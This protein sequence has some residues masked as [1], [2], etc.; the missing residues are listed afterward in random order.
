MEDN[1]KEYFIKDTELNSIDE[2]RLNSKDIADNIE[3]IINNTEPSFAIALT[4]KTGLGK[5]SIINFMIEKYGNNDNYN[6]KKLNLWKDELGLKETLDNE[7]N[8]YS[9]Y[10][11]NTFNDIDNNSPENIEE[12]KFIEQPA[13]EEQSATI[14]KKNNKKAKK[15]LLSILK[16][17]AISGICFLITTAIFLLME[18]FSNSSI[19]SKNDLFFVQNAYLNY[20]ENLSFVFI[21]TLGLTVI[22]Y[23]IETLLSV[24]KSI[25]KKYRIN[26]EQEINLEAEKLTSIADV[27]QKNN[28]NN[29]IDLTKTN[30]VIVEDIDKL[31]L[32][33]MLKTLEDIKYCNNYKNVVLIVPF[34]ENILKKAI[35]ARNELKV[36]KNYKPVKF[37]KIMDKIFQFKISV[38]RISNSNIKNYAIQLANEKVQDF[39]DDY[40]DESTFKNII[41]KI[42]IYKN[43]T[44]PRHVKKLINSFINNKLLIQTR[45]NNGNVDESI[46][47][48]NGFD[49]QLAK[50]SVLQADFED[51][52]DLLFV[53]TG[54]LEKLTDLYC[55]EPTD[56]LE[57]YDRIDDDLKPFFTV[58]YR[59]LKSFLKQTRNYK[60]DN[61]STLIYLT[62]TKPDAFFKDKSLYGYVSGE[63]DVLELRIQE[64]LELVKRLDN[65]ED[66]S[67]FVD[68]NFDKLLDKFE[69]KASNKIFLVNFKQI[70]DIL[71]NYIPEPE[72]IRY[73]KIVANNYNYY[74][75]EALE[76]FENSQI[77]LTVELMNTLLERMQQSISKENFDRTFCFIRNNNDIIFEEGGNVSLY[78]QFLVN[79]ISLSSN[80]DE[81]IIELDD[82]FNRIGKVYE[83]N[84]NIKNLDN[85][86]YESAYKFLAKCLDNG[87]LA[88]MVTVI[89]TILS[90]N[91]SVEDCIKIEEKMTNY[92]LIDV[93]EC[94]ADDIV[95]YEKDNSETSET[96]ENSENKESIENAKLIE[97]NYVLIKNII[98]ICSIKQEEIAPED[99]IKFIEKALLNKDDENYL[100][101]I[102][103]L[104]N[105]FDSAYFYITRRELNDIIYSNFH[106]TQFEEVKKKCVQCTRYF[107]NARIFRPKLNED[108]IKIYNEN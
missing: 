61:I 50:L 42:I 48:N 85:L 107:K 1:L 98:E 102:Y 64:V 95:N 10:D 49:Y 82:N 43:V 92:S 90:D 100:L 88:R 56:L 46:I 35:N 103:D 22:A 105:K 58:K 12:S 68:N 33:K 21:F 8:D 65:E 7:L 16:F 86:D 38:P 44:T 73:L 83:L 69:D 30:I 57:V 99:S 81:V 34:D 3:T 19:Y 104:L 23:I 27:N 25:N 93:I 89:N 80:P 79:N 62:Q 40:C 6:I 75:T 5:S 76:I 47:E 84:K 37:E 106:T 59:P 15:I 66:L 67:E 28:C 14:N 96:I 26:V 71:Y 97:N 72:Y 20:K 63:E 17:I 91:N 36:S 32:S 78:V 39:I 108:E 101:Q 51:F 4:G 52:Y 94:N 13:I 45:V 74:D 9:E 60:I 24:N 41:T 2:D 55:L 11:E 29:R 70:V 31:P 18:Y 54:Y 53:N 87:N 77:V